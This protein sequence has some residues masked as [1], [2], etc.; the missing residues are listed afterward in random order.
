MARQKFTWDEKNNCLVEITEKPKVDAFTFLPDDIPEGIE[1]MVNGQIFTS[2]G[3]L[4]QHY[5]DSGVIEKGNDKAAP[6][7]RRDEE[8]RRQER[9]ERDG[10]ETYY[11]LRDGTIPMDDLTRERCKIID[12]NQEHYCYDRRPIT[13]D[14]EYLE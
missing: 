14:G 1:S 10:V 13:D 6:P 3:R 8:R 9:L 5:R 12:H 4:R 11:G 2:R 7:D